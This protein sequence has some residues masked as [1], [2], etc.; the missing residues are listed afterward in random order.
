M[1]GACRREIPASTAASV[2]RLRTL[3]PEMKRSMNGKRR[4]HASGERLVAGIAL[5]WVDPDE[6]V[7]GSRETCH[8]AR[9]E[10]GSLAL[11]AVRH[12]QH[13]R[14]AR[15]RAPS[16]GVVELGERGADARAAPPVVDCGAAA[17][18]RGRRIA[19]GQ[20]GGE[21]RQRRA[22]REHLD[23]GPGAD[24]RVEEQQE[25]ARVRVHR[26]GDVAQ[27]DQLSRDVL[28]CAHR[29]HD[30]IAARAQRLADQPAHV[31][32]IAARIAAAAARRPPR[33]RARD[34]RDQPAG[35]QEL[36]GRHL[37][38]VL[39]AQQL[40]AGGAELEGIAAGVVRLGVADLTRRRLTDPAGDLDGRPTL[41]RHHR[42][43]HEPRGERAVEQVELVLPRDQRLAQRE[44]DVLLAIDLDGVERPQGVD[45][46]AR[47]YL[48]PGLSQHPSEGDD[49]PDEGVACH[50]RASASRRRCGRR[51]PVRRA[52]R[53]APPR[54]PRGT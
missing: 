8:L 25:R 14:S 45:D 24:R 20:L 41:G 50:G 43:P 4:A 21:A 17:L 32:P 47:P 2:S 34:R 6:G 23:A 31:E 26:P 27:D 11:P 15:E 46:S 29:A 35:E 9:H 52:C 42:R 7:R 40:V 18:E 36:V 37:A 10:L 1:A 53:R 48:E 39:L 19:T 51:R 44:V 5:Q 33:P 49:V 30:G 28:A 16:V 22:E 3:C 54:R 12:D 38:E 13:H